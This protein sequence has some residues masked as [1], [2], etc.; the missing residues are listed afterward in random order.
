MH[1]MEEVLDNAHKI[2]AMMEGAKARGRCAR[3]RVAPLA[4]RAAE[5]TRALAPGCTR[6]AARYRTATPA[7]TPRLATARVAPARKR[8]CARLRVRCLCAREC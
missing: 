2:C 1:T 8:R 3:A 7:T 5:V 4:F 6:R